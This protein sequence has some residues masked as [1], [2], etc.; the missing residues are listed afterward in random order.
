VPSAWS[1]RRNLQDVTKCW[2]PHATHFT[3]WTIRSD[4]VEGADFRTT[5]SGPNRAS[6]VGQ[7]TDGTELL[8]NRDRFC[9]QFAERRF[10]LRV[11]V[12]ARQRA[13]I[14]RR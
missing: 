13:G 11:H 3:A 2:A 8:R 1:T 14:A 7:F 12:G 4:F 6:L 10:D 5:L 9:L